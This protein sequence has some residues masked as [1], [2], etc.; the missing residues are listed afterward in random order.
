MQW[1]S[2][3]YV[4]ITA[5]LIAAKN[6]KQIK[7]LSQE[8]GKVVVYFYNGIVFQKRNEPLIHEQCE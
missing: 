4:I 8:N 5:L 6:W 3:K 1:G 2:E 7:Y